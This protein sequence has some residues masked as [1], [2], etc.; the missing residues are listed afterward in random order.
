MTVTLNIEKA[1]NSLG[2]G[3]L[4]LNTAPRLCTHIPLVFPKCVCM[5]SSNRLLEWELEVGGGR[6]A[7][8][9]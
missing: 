1:A 4:S 7:G 8:M 9:R 3:G 5:D 6:V 2:A